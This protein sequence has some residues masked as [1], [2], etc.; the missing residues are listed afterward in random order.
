MQTDIISN[1]AVETP[2]AP[3]DVEERSGRLRH[4]KDDVIRLD[5]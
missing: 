1:T 3:S 4:H 2:S 5:S